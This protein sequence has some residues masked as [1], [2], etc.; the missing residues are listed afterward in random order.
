[1]ARALERGNG[2]GHRRFERARRDRPAL[3]LA[4][5]RE[6]DRYRLLRRQVVV[7]SDHAARHTGR[8][9]APLDNRPPRLAIEAVVTEAQLAITR[10]RIEPCATPLAP[11]PPNLEDV[12]KISVEVEGERDTD[13]GAAVVPQPD[14]L[15]ARAV[16][17]EAP[18]K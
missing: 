2:F 13:V 10:D 6:R 9:F 16:P 15:V 1:G 7:E 17:E 12:G 4:A 14:P 18:A 11:R 8:R 5:D 3:A